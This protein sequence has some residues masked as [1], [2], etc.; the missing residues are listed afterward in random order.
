M[1]VDNNFITLMNE[2]QAS[3][4]ADEDL[5]VIA[6]HAFQENSEET[7]GAILSEDPCN[8]EDSAG[9]PLGSD[10]K[11]NENNHEYDSP[12][13]PRPT[14]PPASSSAP[15]E[16]SRSFFCSAPDVFGSI[17]S[18]SLLA[19]PFYNHSPLPSLPGPSDFLPPARNIQANHSASSTTIAVI[20]D[21]NPQS[22]VLREGARAWREMHNR[23][24]SRNVGVDFRTGMSGHSGLLN[25]S[26]HKLGSRGRTLFSMSNH[27]G[28]SMSKSRRVYDDDSSLPENSITT[29]PRSPQSHNY[30]L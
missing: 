23:Q 25:N 11:E 27:S 9:Y 3:L 19:Q 21:S 10:V 17:P 16:D 5:T 14:E 8:N 28:L 2:L 22:N 7:F 4:M 13:K 12:L 1:R 18:P 30:Y 24:E 20:N 29:S 6:A 26:G 15:G